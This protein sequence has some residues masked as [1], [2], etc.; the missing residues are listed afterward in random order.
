MSE[1]GRKLAASQHTNCGSRYCEQPMCMYMCMR[2]Q[3]QCCRMHINILNFRFKYFSHRTSCCSRRFSFA[4][5]PSLLFRRSFSVMLPL[6]GF[7]SIVFLF[8][9]HPY[10]ISA[11]PC[12]LPCN[13]SL[14]SHFASSNIGTHKGA[15]LQDKYVIDE[16]GAAEV[17]FS[18][19]ARCM[20]CS[21][22][23]IQF[24]YYFH[25]ITLDYGFI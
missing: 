21:G 12:R 15:T 3:E 5:L 4:S 22:C 9:S 25:E 20:G 14:N 16:L 13:F 11:A 19:C 2:C 23:S 6:V 17:Y 18:L 24:Y 8:L 10:P 7:H 1:Y